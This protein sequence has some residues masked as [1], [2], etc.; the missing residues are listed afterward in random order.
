MRYG[1]KIGKKEPRQQVG[2]GPHMV[3]LA[4]PTAV[5][6]TGIIPWIHHTRVKKAAASC[7]EDTWK[8][9]W[10]PENPLK[11]WFQKQWSSLTKDADPCS[12]HS[13]SW[14]VHARQKLEASSALLQPH[15]SSCLVN[16]WQKLKDLAIKISMDIY[17]QPWPL[18]LIGIIAVL[19]AI[20][21]AS[22]TAQDWDLDQ[23]LQ[24]ALCYLIIVGSLILIRCL[25]WSILPTN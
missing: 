6:V 15:S 2:T 18:S 20:G 9:V 14:L 16:A 23:K 11:V 7:N 10:D 12:S 19:F 8:T 1:L 21:L 3:V 13:R 24:L 4:T 5:K 17:C 25:L 22:V